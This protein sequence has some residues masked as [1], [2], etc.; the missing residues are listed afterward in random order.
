MKKI[1]VLILLVSFSFIQAFAQDSSK[2]NLPDLGVVSKKATQG[3]YAI[4]YIYRAKSK[5]IS[6][7]SFTI[8]VNDSAVCKI[9]SNERYTIKIY[10]FGA[11]NL[12]AKSESRSDL[13]VNVQMG[14]EYYIK[15]KVKK[16]FAGEVPN[17]V[18]IEPEIGKTEF[19]DAEEGY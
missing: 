5:K 15:C 17:L 19:D 1:L 12:W 8:N 6:F 18:Q 11:T 7:A 3:K 2:I 9:K 13:T 16:G 14:K 4:L 10:K